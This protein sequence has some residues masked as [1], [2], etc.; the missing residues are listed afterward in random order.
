M[1]VAIVKYNAGNVCSVVN[2]LTR[3]GFDPLLTADA[4]MLDKADRVL[5]TGQGEARNAMQ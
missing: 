2:A 1:N 5:F 4:A 3:L